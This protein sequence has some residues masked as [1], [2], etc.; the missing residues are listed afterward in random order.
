MRAG[1]FKLPHSIGR[2][3]SGLQ[4]EI[5]RI[6]QSLALKLGQTISEMEPWAAYPYPA[7][8]IARYLANFDARAPRY[9]LRSD[10]EVVGAVGLQLNWL[11][12]PYIQFLA[13]LPPFQNKG[14]GALVLNWVDREA[15]DTKARN[16]WVISSDF[17]VGA[18]AFYEKHGFVEV[19]EISDIVCDGRTETLMRKRTH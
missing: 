13:V 10:D 19:C 9:V 3:T 18:R 12:G 15:G 1:E 14:L 16:V 4:V 11:H 7:D 2:A 6:D 5:D 17:N 8:K